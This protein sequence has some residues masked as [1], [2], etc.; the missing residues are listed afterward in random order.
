MSYRLT[1]FNSDFGHCKFYSDHSKL[2]Q[3]LHRMANRKSE[4]QLFSLV[5]T[6]EKRYRVC[7]LMIINN[8][9][10]LPEA[11]LQSLNDHFYFLQDSII[12][13]DYSNR[14]F[15]SYNEELL[16]CFMSSKNEK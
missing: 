4:E 12:F 11:Y 2:E 6:F 15:G 7:L 3:G 13:Y 5:F 16:K 10:I 8:K 9:Y 1:D 14:S